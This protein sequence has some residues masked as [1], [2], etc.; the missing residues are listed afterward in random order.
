MGFRQ[1]YPNHSVIRS[2]VLMHQQ[3][4][5]QQMLHVAQLAEDDY[6]SVQCIA[7]EAI[8]LS[9]AFPI[10][11]NMSSPMRATTFPSQVET[12]LT[13][14]QGGG[15]YSTN[16]TWSTA[17][18]SH[19]QPCPWNCFGCGGPHPTPSTRTELMLIFD[20]IGRYQMFGSMLQGT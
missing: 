13:Q 18:S 2:L 9:Q 7:H 5:L 6:G 8:G 16:S 12:M 3:K 20:P 19:G 4:I 1:F 14:Y 17:G 11:I 10:I 15:G